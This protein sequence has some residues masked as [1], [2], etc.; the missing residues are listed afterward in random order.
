V[1]DDADPSFVWVVVTESV[2]YQCNTG[3]IASLAPQLYKA[4]HFNPY[5]ACELWP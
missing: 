1:S 2:M 5:G 4:L 3:P